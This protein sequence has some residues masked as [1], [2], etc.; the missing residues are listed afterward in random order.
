MKKA[1]IIEKLTPLSE[2]LPVFIS[3]LDRNSGRNGHISDVAVNDI[4]DTNTTKPKRPILLDESE[5]EAELE[6]SLNGESESDSKSV[7]DSSDE[8]STP[9]SGEWGDEN[10]YISTKSYKDEFA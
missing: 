10:N 2:L 4:I 5:L 3:T 1:E 6:L 8:N 9:D 7:S